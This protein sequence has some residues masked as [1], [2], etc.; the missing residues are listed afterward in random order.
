VFDPDETS[1]P[2]S[3][4]IP[5]F[6]FDLIERVTLVGALQYA[7]TKTHSLALWAV[8]ITG[9]VMLSWWLSRYIQELIYAIIN[10]AW[11]GIPTPW[12][13][14]RAMRIAVTLITLA[15]CYY[16]GMFITNAIDQIVKAASG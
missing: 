14:S 4:T 5:K 10:R 12:S 7:F 6:V 3:E 15:P 11:R 16:A 13:D 8:G 9:A 1:Q 2:R